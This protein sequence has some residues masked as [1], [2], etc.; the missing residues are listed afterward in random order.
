MF[1]KTANLL[2]YNAQKQIRL[3]QIV[4]IDLKNFNLEDMLK[5]NLLFLAK[6]IKTC[7]VS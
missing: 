5:V 3:E 6:L 4:I 2:E 7:Q 1:Q